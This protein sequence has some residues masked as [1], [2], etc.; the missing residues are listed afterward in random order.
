MDIKFYPPINHTNHGNDP[1]GKNMAERLEAMPGGTAM[2][3]LGG[4]DDNFIKITAT[5]TDMPRCP[6][7]DYAFQMPL[8]SFSEKCQPISH[9][10]VFNAC[11]LADACKTAEF[12]VMD[13]DIAQSDDG[14]FIG[15]NSTAPLDV[16]KVT[17]ELD[18]LTPR[19]LYSIPFTLKKPYDMTAADWDK[20]TA[21]WNETHTGWDESAEFSDDVFMSLQETAQEVSDE[22]FH[23]DLITGESVLIDLSSG[24]YQLG[25]AHALDGEKLT[26]LSKH[27]HNM[28]GM[29]FSGQFQQM[30]MLTDNDLKTLD[31][32]SM[33]DD[34]KDALDALK[35]ETGG[36]EQ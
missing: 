20:F 9:R 5:K 3:I 8:S 36:L 35:Q 7:Y 24:Y 15:L 33:G 14:V 26:L 28:H 18:K 6:R 34:L 27:I 19:Y 12:R 11:Q 22:D 13:I 16:C 23:D 17:D 10:A 2:E 29:V 31:A 25:S 1:A 21:E 4:K 32:P 30:A